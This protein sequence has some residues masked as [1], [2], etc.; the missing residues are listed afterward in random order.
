MF[1]RLTTFFSDENGSVSVDYTVLS[2]AAVSMAI[3]ATVVIT[4]GI[5]FITS[6]V[7][8]EL[9]ERQ[10]ND[11]FIDFKP[12]HF[13]PLLQANLVT[14]DDALQLW[15]A[16][17]AKMNQDIINA[18]Q[19]GIIKIQEGTISQEE[20]GE[21]FALASVAY[22]RNVV[23]DAVLEYYFGFDGG[24]PID[25]TPPAQYCGDPNYC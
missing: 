2:A 6:A 17:N 1:V 10:L 3:A 23:D 16:A 9:R 22:Q 24:Q 18:L 14:E 4:G 12:A 11:T 7:D 13:E 20:L 21:L 8:A 15:N 25:G 19:E 5:D